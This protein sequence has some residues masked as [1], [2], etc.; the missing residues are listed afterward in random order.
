MGNE[1]IGKTGAF[2]CRTQDVGRRQGDAGT[3][4]MAAKR[5][6]ENLRDLR[7]SW[8]HELKEQDARL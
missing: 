7:T 4:L 5:E 8:P 3:S 1:V 2:F 6:K